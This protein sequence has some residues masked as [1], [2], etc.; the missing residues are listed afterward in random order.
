MT[1]TTSSRPSPASPRRAPTFLS[2]SL[3]RS[4]TVPSINLPSLTPHEPETNTRLG[5][6]MADERN[7]AGG[8]ARELCTTGQRGAECQTKYRLIREE[9]SDAQRWPLQANLSAGEPCLRSNGQREWVV[10]ARIPVWTCTDSE[11]D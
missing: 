9:G 4:W 10:S 1:A 6:E 5:V 2:A 8:G 7:G 11:E 3:V